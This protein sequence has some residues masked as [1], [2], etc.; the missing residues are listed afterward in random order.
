MQSNPFVTIF[1][2]TVVILVHVE[3]YAQSKVINNK[4]NSSVII[5]DGKGNLVLNLQYKN[6]CV[7]NELQVM[8]QKVVT[9][10]K[11]I[12][13]AIQVK[14]KWSTTGDEIASPKVSA[15]PDMVQVDNI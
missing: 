9:N 14:D 12:F 4:Q 6:R 11:G 13:S 1:A 5:K 2:I 8:G 15:T 7:I 10:D 3:C